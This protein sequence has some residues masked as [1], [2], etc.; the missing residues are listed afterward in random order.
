MDEEINKLP[1][2]AKLIRNESIQ[3]HRA[4]L[5]LLDESL[6]LDKGLINSKKITINRYLLNKLLNFFQN[7]IQGLETSNKNKL[8]IFKLIDLIKT[9]ETSFSFEQNFENEKFQE[10]KKE[11][12]K[13]KIENEN[14]KKNQQLLNSVNVEY[15]EQVN[16]II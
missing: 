2:E 15:S 14:L 6:H 3:S 10:I 5:S 9:E 11:A 8:T 16:Y 13:L 4:S 12:E 7:L 1:H